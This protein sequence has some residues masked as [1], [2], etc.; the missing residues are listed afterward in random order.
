MFYKSLDTVGVNMNNGK[1]VIFK[2]G[3]N[4]FFGF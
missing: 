4:N 3:K 1:S 2:Q